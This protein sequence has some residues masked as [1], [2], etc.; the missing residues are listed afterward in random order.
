[1]K[2][3]IELKIDRAGRLVIPKPIRDRLG[4]KPGARL[5]AREHDNQL[6]LKSVSDQP[7]LVRE[8]GLWVHQGEPTGSLDLRRAIDEV[9]EERHRAIV[10]S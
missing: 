7:A 8:K 4:L 3:T 10:E 5:E 6:I 1:M 2:N 9:R